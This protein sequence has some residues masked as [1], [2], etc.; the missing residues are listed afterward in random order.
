[1]AIQRLS[2]VFWRHVLGGFT[3]GQEAMA[4]GVGI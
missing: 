1:M 4:V 3:P 2:G